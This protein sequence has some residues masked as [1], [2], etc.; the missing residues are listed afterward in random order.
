MGSSV[1]LSFQTVSSEP[2]LCAS[3]LSTSWTS[4]HC[5]LC[6]ISTVSLFLYFSFILSV[7]HRIFPIS[8]LSPWLS[9]LFFGSS[10]VSPFFPYLSLLTVSFR[11]L[12]LIEIALIYLFLLLLFPFH[13]F[14]FHSIS[15]LFF[16]SAG[17]TAPTLEPSNRN[18]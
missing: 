12:A 10:A 9:S 1:F 11:Y 17:V 3:S 2:S 18:D 8:L 7:I 13:L 6:P 5:F 16:P 15:H 14:L 4:Q